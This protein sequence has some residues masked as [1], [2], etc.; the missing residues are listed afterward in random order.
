METNTRTPG[1][2]LGRAA[3]TLA[4][5]SLRSQRLVILSRNWRCREGELD[6]VAT[7]G[8]RLIVVEVKARSSGEFGSPAEA[9]TAAKQARI[10]AATQAWLRRYQLGWCPVRFD[11][12]SVLWPPSGEPRLEHFG[13]AFS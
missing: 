5:A 3:E 12:V 6:I 11:V 9:I 7:D 8:Y 13:G 1:H 2:D 4:A 10:R